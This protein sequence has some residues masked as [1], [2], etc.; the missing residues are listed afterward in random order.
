MKTL[1]PLKS[2]MHNKSM[3]LLIKDLKLLKLNTKGSFKVLSK[4]LEMYNNKKF[5]PNM[6][7]K[8]VFDYYVVIDYE[9]TCDKQE[10]NF[11]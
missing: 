6:C 3:A 11:E 8:V 10:K 2:R 9:A 5:L 4:R 1:P 7:G